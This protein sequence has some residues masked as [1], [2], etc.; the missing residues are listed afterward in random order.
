[1]PLR[2]NLG[3]PDDYAEPNQAI[4]AT[5]ESSYASGIICNQAAWNSGHQATRA[6]AGDATYFTEMYGNLPANTRRHTF[7]FNHIRPVINM[8]SGHQR[9][10][11]KSTTIVPIENADDV[12]ADQF[13]KVMMWVEDQESVLQT[14]SQSFHDALVTGMTLLQVWVDYREDPISG[15]IKVDNCPYNAF[16][17]DPFFKKTDL[18]DCNYIW[19]RTFLTKR[20]V[21]SLMPD[22]GDII[23][24]LQGEGSR[25]GKFQFLAEAYNWNTKNLLS[26]DEYYYRDYRKQKLMIDTQ[27]GECMEWKSEN[28]EGL[29]QFLEMYPMVTM[30]EGDIPTVR[31]AIV[32][33][34]RVL[35]DGPNPMG[36]DEYPFAA[37]TAYYN[38]QM[39]EFDMRIQGVVHGLIDAQYLYNRRQVIGLDILE[40]QINSGWK[41][42][43]DALVN[44]KDVYQSGQ[45]KGLALK[46]E[47]Q[48]TDVEQILPPQIPN[49]MMEMTKVLG[50]EINKI[51]GVSD[52]LLGAASDDVAG[53]LSMLRQ[54]AG[55]TT[56]Q[57]LFDQLDATQKNLGKIIMSLIQANFTPGKV[58]RILGGEEPTAQFYNKAFGKYGVTITDGLNSVTQRQ[59]QFAQLMELKRMEIPIPNDVLI[60]ACSL[61]NKSELIEALKKQQ[62]SQEQM[63]QMRM[64]VEMEEIT[65]RTRLS[66]ARSVAD[67]GL[68]VERMSR[69]EENKALAEERRAQAHR[70][71]DAGTL[72]MIKAIQEIEHM[73]LDHVIKALTMVNTIRQGENAIRDSQANRASQASEASQPQGEV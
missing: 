39:P 16:L 4:L 14:V 46:T 56:L 13:T 9:Q 65:A 48:M 57:A 35:Y 1:M 51:S 20:E 10:N 64:Q 12:T 59:M 33:Q 72:D 19:K 37:M 23:M 15:Q 29:K 66:N 34:G 2:Q 67:H 25:D 63:E 62:E 3:T 22:K 41:Y 53:V 17:I 6:E 50:D 27:T 54:G 26:Y 21:L 52:E 11:R 61:Q 42:K 28:D 44:P 32:C 8:I 55:L 68:G 43:E 45:G 38:P 40:S 49:S 71:E 73:D 60:E 7:S 31:L 30:I 69:V 18:S 5:M 36:I 24:A 58:K 47:A 70:D